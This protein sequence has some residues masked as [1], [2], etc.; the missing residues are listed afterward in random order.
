MQPSATPERSF[1][2]ARRENMASSKND[3]KTFQSRKNVFVKFFE[4]DVNA[5]YFMSYNWLLFIV[6]HFF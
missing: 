4:Y 6:G 1:F 5:V 2:L 3:P